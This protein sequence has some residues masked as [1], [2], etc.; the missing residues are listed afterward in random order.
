MK[1]CLIVDKMH[2]SIIPL[3]N[4]IGFQADYRPNITRKEVLEQIAE[5]DGLI[6]RSKLQIDREFIEQASQLKF[7]GRAGAGLDQLDELALQEY[8]I[9]ILNAPEGNRDALAEHALGML[10][11]LLNRISLADQE[12]R[13]GVWDREGNRGVELMGKT[14]G[15]IGYGYMGQAFAQRLSGFGVTVLA[16]DKYKQDYGNAFAREATMSE[17]FEKADI[18]SLHVPLTSETQFLVDESYLSQFVKNIY[19]INTARGK[20]I[21]LSDLTKALER[22]KVRGAALDVLENEKL[23]QLTPQ[24]QHSFD[25]LRQTERVLF[26]PHVAGWTFESYEKINQTLVRKIKAL[27]LT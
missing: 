19:L 12:I 14:V 15:I 6:V 3:L 22:G 11:N 27:N 9:S 17:V 24:Q 8:H 4:D 10:L 20:V 26:S 25:Q 23:Q 16:Y 2:D 7:V 1:K 5:Y 13:K 21:R 18:L